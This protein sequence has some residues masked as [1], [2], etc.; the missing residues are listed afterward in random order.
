MFLP[1]ETEIVLGSRH[2]EVSFPVMLKS[3]HAPQD[4]IPDIPSSVDSLGSEAFGSVG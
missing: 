3:R 1:G 2:I 4:G